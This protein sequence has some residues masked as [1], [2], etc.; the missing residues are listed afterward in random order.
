MG[1]LDCLL[2]D[3]DDSNCFE[4]P[5]L[6][7]IDGPLNDKDDYNQEINVGLN[8]WTGE[9]NNN[10]VL[11]FNPNF[12]EKCPTGNVNIS[13]ICKPPENNEQEID[14][15][16]IDNDSST[17]EDIEPSID[18]D[19]VGGDVV[20][21]E[22]E[23]EIGDEVVNENENEEEEADGGE[24]EVGD[25][26]VDENEGVDGDDEVHDI[27]T[28]KNINDNTRFIVIIGL[29]LLFLLCCKK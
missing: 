18:S 22:L 8:T 2:S 29:L 5:K 1:I 9:K 24:E 26:V 6:I 20:V 11:V 23:E 19:E 12:K 16:P 13:V 7:K 17:G 25:E 27:E 28:F 4:N 15:I 21:N 3:N 14:N 10:Y